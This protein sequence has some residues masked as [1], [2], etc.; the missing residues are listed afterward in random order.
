MNFQQK[1]DYENSPMQ[2]SNQNFPVL[3]QPMAHTM[4]PITQPLGNMGSQIVQPNIDQIPSQST[5]INS[6]T[7][8]V[9]A[10]T[11]TLAECD[12]KPLP[13]MN[14]QQNEASQTDNGDAIA[15]NVPQQPESQ[16]TVENYL[17]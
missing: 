17:N 5:T 13:S 9:I 8:Q 6:N 12:V 4:R 11:T 3:A 15:M 2:I 10:P 16:Q 7:S 1:S 14:K